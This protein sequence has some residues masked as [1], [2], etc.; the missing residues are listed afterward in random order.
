[1]SGP[2]PLPLPLQTAR[3]AHITEVL[4]QVNLFVH[5]PEEAIEGLART[6]RRHY[7][8][9]GQWDAPAHANRTVYVVVHGTLRRYRVS[10]AGLQITLHDWRPGD[11]IVRP[12]S[13]ADRQTD[14]DI[15]V[16]GE[17][18]LLY[19]LSWTS[20][21]QD[22]ATCPT[23]AQATFD[24]LLTRIGDLEDRLT[25]MAVNSLLVRVA[26]ALMRHSRDGINCMMTRAQLS[27]LVGASREEVG[28]VLRHL[29]AEG[30]ISYAD[31][32][33]TFHILDPD[34]L[35]ALSTMEGKQPEV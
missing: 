27:N 8:R 23:A 22:L 20:V 35:A 19:A 3:H 33:R 17:G 10:I 26:H 6:V 12:G 34:R 18:A 5:L 28:R 4:R 15:D 1:M 24:V 21:F 25:D 9:P 14:D 7:L 11:L 16:G 31:Y 32:G 13:T 29:R 30:L 2:A